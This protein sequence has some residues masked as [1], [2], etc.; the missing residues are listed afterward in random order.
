MSFGFQPVKRPAAIEAL[1]ICL[2]LRALTFRRILR[3][4]HRNSGESDYSYPDGA[5]CWLRPGSTTCSTDSCLFVSI[6]GL[7]MEP[8]KDTSNI[9]R[10]KNSGVE[11]IKLA[12]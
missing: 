2:D 9:L 1:V 8:L 6:R 10:L 7:K 11:L 5:C 4:G 3:N 12:R